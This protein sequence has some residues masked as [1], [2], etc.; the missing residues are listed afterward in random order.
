MQMRSTDEIIEALGGPKVLAQ[1]LG[2]QTHHAVSN[3][4]TR[5]IAW[6]RRYQVAEMLR[7]A[8]MEPPPGFLG[9]KDE[10]KAGQ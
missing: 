4:R 5:G 8:G 10:R 2:Y 1:R 6:H 3:W 9:V 7:E